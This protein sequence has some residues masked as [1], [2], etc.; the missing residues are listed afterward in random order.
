MCGHNG[1]LSKHEAKNSSLSNNTSVLT[2][3]KHLPKQTWKTAKRVLATKVRLITNLTFN[4]LKMF[5]L[6]Y[7]PISFNIKQTLTNASLVK[8]R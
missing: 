6:W 1:D 2:I 7:K 4:P 3:N 8:S 5:F